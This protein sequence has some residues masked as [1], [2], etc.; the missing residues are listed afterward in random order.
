MHKVKTHRVAAVSVKIATQKESFQEFKA[1]KKAAKEEFY[2]EI[3]GVCDESKLKT[4]LLLLFATDL[5][6]EKELVDRELL[7]RV[8]EGCRVLKLKVVV[9]DTQEPGEKFSQ[10]HDITWLNP[11][12][13]FRKKSSGQKEIDR[14]FLAADMA[15]VFSAHSDLMRLLMSYGVVLLAK[16]QSPILESYHPNTEEGNSFLFDEYD[17]WAIFATLVRATETYR[18]PFDWSHIVRGLVK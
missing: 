13:A 15:L 5:N 1:E 12:T 2:G 6:G 8:L 9:V 7:F 10:H 18:F 3:E 16:D 11:T 17:A 14:L 4:P